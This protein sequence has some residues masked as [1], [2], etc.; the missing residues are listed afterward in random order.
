MPCV[1]PSRNNLRVQGPCGI[2][3]VYADGICKWHWQMQNGLIRPSSGG[4]DD[5]QTVLLLHMEGADGSTTFTDAKGH[6]FTASGTAK[7]S[8]AQAKFG[9]SSGL[10][11]QSAALSTPD[12]ADFAFGAGDFT[13]DLWARISAANGANAEVF[14]SQYDAA[15]QISWYFYMLAGGQLG[16]YWSTDGSAALG[17]ASAGVAFAEHLVPRR[18]CAK[19]ER[20]NALC[21]RGSGRF[22][23]DDG[24]AEGLNCSAQD[25]L[26]LSHLQP[27]ERLAR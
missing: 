6:P 18:C 20:G 10:F 19:R 5:P 3:D 7:I 9:G 11:D 24:I 1:A 22:C 2:P 14:V 13:I 27:D 21:E 25:R 23:G 26:R 4:A 12:H 17:V 15:P 8:T 16:F